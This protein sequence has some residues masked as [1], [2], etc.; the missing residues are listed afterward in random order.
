MI[1]YLRSVIKNINIHELGISCT[2]LDNSKY[3]R[4]RN[5]KMVYKNFYYS[6]FALL[7]LL[8]SL[9]S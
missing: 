7:I 4:T 6:D 9:M 1:I 3:E 5:F 2:F 8:S